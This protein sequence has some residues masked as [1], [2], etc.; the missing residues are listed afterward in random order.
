M[1]FPLGR[2]LGVDRHTHALSSPDV[3]H[4]SVAAA[5]LT[6]Y[7]TLKADSRTDM[8]FRTPSVDKSLRC[9]LIV[10]DQRDLLS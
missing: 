8:G 5:I 2:L 3:V 1:G 10:D 6:C 4:R 7:R 9:V